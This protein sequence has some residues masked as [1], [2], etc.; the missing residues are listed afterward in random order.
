MGCKPIFRK[1]FL[2]YV[3]EMDACAEHGLYIAR[4]YMSLQVREQLYALGGLASPW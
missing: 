1:A 4:F 2:D 3:R